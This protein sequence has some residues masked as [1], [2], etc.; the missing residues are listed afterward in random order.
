MPNAENDAT[1]PVGD[2]LACA[3]WK[4]YRNAHFGGPGDG[5]VTWWT[6]QPVERAMWQDMA[7]FFRDAV[8]THPDLAAWVA[9]RG[10]TRV[11][12]PERTDNE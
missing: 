2:L 4:C 3:L 5:T 9:E 12:P 7:A 8:E 6:L 11:I 1:I 10:Y